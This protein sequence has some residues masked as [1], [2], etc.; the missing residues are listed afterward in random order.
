MRYT[1]V[2]RGTANGWSSPASSRNMR[3]WRREIFRS[4]SLKP[5]GMFQPSGPNLRLSW[6]TAW[7][8]QMENSSFLWLAGSLHSSMYSSVILVYDRI[9]LAFKP[10]GGS[11]VILMPFCRIATGNAGDGMAESQSLNSGCTASA[12]IVS[13]MT[14]SL[15]IHDS[16][17]WQFCRHTHMPSSM[18]LSIIAS[19]LG[20]CP[21]PSDTWSNRC[22][23]SF[24]SHSLRRSAIGSAP[25]D[26]TKMS[27]AST[28]DSA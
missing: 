20:P 11:S 27:G 10:L 3:S 22:S 12:S 9:R 6:I 2:F 8:R 13:Q 18:A 21:W 26:S 28:L 14:S 25:E 4:G 17:R 19:A 5:Y 7:K 23:I 16:A 24:S 15:G 1:S